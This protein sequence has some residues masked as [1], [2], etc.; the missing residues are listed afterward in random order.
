MPKMGTIT[1]KE[2]M[3]EALK[4]S[5]GV[6]KVACEQCRVPRGTHDDWMRNDLEYRANVEQVYE[7]QIDFAESSLLKQIR[8]GVPQSTIF[9]LKTKGRKRGY[10][11]HIEQT[12][13]NINI[14]AGSSHAEIAEKL[15]ADVA[16]E[17][18]AKL[19]K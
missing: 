16:D 8:D 19:L 12:N 4:K 1:K 7:E 11:E 6:I 18:F 5:L 14:D 2:N 13:T 3:I 9:F 10:N 17:I 15:G